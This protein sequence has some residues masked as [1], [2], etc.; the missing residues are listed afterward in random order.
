VV[1]M[2]VCYQNMS[3]NSS[4]CQ[5]AYWSEFRSG[6]RTCETTGL[7]CPAN[8]AVGSSDHLVNDHSARMPDVDPDMEH[9]GFSMVL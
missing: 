4:S 1:Q 3:G 2:H 7:V 5:F 9:V 6:L 8:H